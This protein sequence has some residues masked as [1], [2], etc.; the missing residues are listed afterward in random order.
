MRAPLQWPLCAC[1]ARRGCERKFFA[2]TIS[3]ASRLVMAAAAC[4]A[5]LLPA[6]IL[7][8]QTSQTMPDMHWRGE[9]VEVDRPNKLVL[10]M[11]DDPGDA[12]ETV[13]VTLTAVDG[14]T[15]MEFSQ[16]RRD[17]TIAGT[18]FA[19]GPECPRRQALG[20]ASGVSG[21]H[22]PAPGQP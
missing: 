4:A 6:P 19:R 5:S 13:T 16:I 10:T 14:G 20:T 2:L 7:R 17:Q 21:E 11:T 22:A 15:E 9:Y 1:V 8:A 3:S 12:R 18:S